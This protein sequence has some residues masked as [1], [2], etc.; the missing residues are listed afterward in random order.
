MIGLSREHVRG[1]VSL[2]PEAAPPAGTVREL[3][4]LLSDG[5]HR[6]SWSQLFADRPPAVLLVDDPRLDVPDPYGR[7]ALEHITTIHDLSM[8]SAAVTD[9]LAAI[10]EGSRSA[11]P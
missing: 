9:G 2:R 3:A 8:L 4:R 1:V 5:A 10:P 11:S 7:P 6:P